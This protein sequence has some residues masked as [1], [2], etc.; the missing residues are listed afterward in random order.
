MSESPDRLAF[1]FELERLMAND[2]PET[3]P[4]RVVVVTVEPPAWCCGEELARIH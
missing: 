1:L 2:Y 4:F 3:G